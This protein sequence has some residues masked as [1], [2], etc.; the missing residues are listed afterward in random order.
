MDEKTESLR[1]IFLDVADDET[2]VESQSETHG[3][4]TDEGDHRDDLLAVVEQIED[5]FDRSVA[6]D[7]DTVA[8]LIEAFYAG[9][10]DT[11]IAETCEID[12]ESVFETRMALHCYRE[13][14]SPLDLDRVAETLSLADT[15]IDEVS[16]DDRDR[17]ADALDADR[18]AID[19]AIGVLR[20]RREARSVSHRFRTAYEDVLPDTDISESLTASIKEDGLDEAAEDIETDVSL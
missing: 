3:S 6:F 12:P 1:D 16:D 18:A 11:T 20:A 4:I 10:D 13:S 14:D 5:A 9:D 19:R 8:T 15:A 7:D 17:A 2:V